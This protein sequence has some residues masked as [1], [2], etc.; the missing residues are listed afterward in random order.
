MQEFEP[1]IGIETHIALNTKTKMFC[2]CENVFGENPN[3]KCCPICIGA[4]GTLPRLNKKVIQYA[5][6]AG[7]ATSC[8]ISPF[9]SFDRKHY[10][11]PDLPKGYQISQYFH[12]ICKNG[13]LNIKCEEGIRRIGISQIH[14]EEDAGR[15]VLSPERPEILVDFNRAGIP[16]LEIVSKPDIH[17]AKDAICYLKE[18]KLLIEH[19]NISNCKMQEGSFRSDINISIKRKG[20]KSL[21]IKTEIKNLNSFK[22]IKKAIQEEI[23]RQ[24]KTKI[25]G[26][27]IEPETMRWDENSKACIS[28][29]EKKA[30]LDYKF[31]PEP[32]IPVIH[33]L[34]EDIKRQRD[35][36]EELPQAKRK[37]YKE[38]YF[39]S[40][41]I[42]E[43]I[44][45]DVLLCKLFE[46]TLK[47]VKNITPK[48]VSNWITGEVL[49]A[50]NE[51][52][53]EKFKS[54]LTPKA[55]AQIIKMTRKDL[56]NRNIAGELIIKVIKTSVSPV[57]YVNK[58]NLFSF[59]D[60]ETI[61]N[62]V[63]Q[64]IDNN[65]QAVENYIEG[66]KKALTFLMGECMKSAG[67]KGNPTIIRTILLNKLEQYVF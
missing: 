49:R 26:R 52:V 19:L 22:S 14:M 62:L 32:D 16:L 41:S 50:L 57:D 1:V 5:I 47:K 65:P 43:I 54:N 15:I 35:S 60:E 25:S 33:I 21:G 31:L 27:E 18:L 59:Q 39:L 64:V 20:E 45:N 36:L 10:F 40:E 9:T 13:F 63:Q 30:T 66:K 53:D 38:K 6:R 8:E 12:P 48:E 4:P 3:S 24:I 7:V 2:G 44:L 28:M 46:E 55:L 51:N 56:I 17:S 34:K 42:I 58:Y 67:K 11:Y 61:I 37:R 23:A 29:R